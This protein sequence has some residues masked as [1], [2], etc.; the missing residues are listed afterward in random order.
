MSSGV[1]AV[2]RTDESEYALTL[3]RGFSETDVDAIEITMTVPNALDVIERLIGEGVKRV[4][5]GTVRTIEQVQKLSKIGASFVVSPNLDERIVKE[6]VN[7]GIPVTPGTLTP[8]EMVQAL[9]WGAT[10]EKVFPINAMGGQDYVKSVL[11]PL[12]D[13]SLVVSGGVQTYEVNSYLDLGCVGVCLGGALWRLEDAASGESNKVR[14]YA[15]AA[16]ARVAIG[17]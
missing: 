17:R 6:A 9:Q 14:A 12:P 15:E 3:G 7:L 8:S 2:I 13:L 5:G 16:L 4:G 10:S 11:E 1:I